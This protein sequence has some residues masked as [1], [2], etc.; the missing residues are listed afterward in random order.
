MV[1]Q[2]LK[3]VPDHL[4]TQAMCESAVEDE[5]ES[6]EFIPDNLKTKRCVK[7]PL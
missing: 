3:Y 6:L 5:P 2:M 4:K 7:E 1:S